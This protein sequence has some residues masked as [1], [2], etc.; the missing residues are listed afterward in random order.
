MVTGNDCPIGKGKPHPYPY[1]KGL[2]KA[3]NIRPEEAI[4]IENAP[5]G[6]KAAKA[7]GIFTVAVNT[8]PLDPQVL[9]DA[10]ADIVLGSMTELAE[11]VVAIAS[12]DRDADTCHSY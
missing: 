3:G 6:V 5:L 1:L 2:E 11:K 8:G 7:A 4:V 12:A 9:K 10:G